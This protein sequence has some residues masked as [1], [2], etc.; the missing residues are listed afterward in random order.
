[1]AANKPPRALYLPG[2]P[3]SPNKMTMNDIIM[4]EE[5]VKNCEYIKIP[6][7]YLK[8]CDSATQ[9]ILLSYLVSMAHINDQFELTNDEIIEFLGFGR[10]E[11]NSAKKI[12]RKKGFINVELRGSP[13]KS[14]YSVNF[15]IIK[16]A[17][18]SL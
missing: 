12:L 9:A 16:K 18:D 8:I 3:Q 10:N 1:M 17:T 14:N 5:R 11:F 6:Y 15:D 2:I 13:A 7:N 4:F